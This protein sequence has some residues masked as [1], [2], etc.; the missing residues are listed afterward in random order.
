MLDRSRY[1]NGHV[2]IPIWCA[3]IHGTLCQL[4]TYIQ[5]LS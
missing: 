3:L 2:T 1:D 5:S 4:A